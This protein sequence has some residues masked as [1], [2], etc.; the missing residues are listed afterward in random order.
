LTP[1][2]SVTGLLRAWRAG[3]GA[4]LERLT[5][6][7]YDELR[8]IARRSLRRERAGHSLQATA[9]VHE[10]YL[11]LVGAQAVEWQDRAHFFA[12]AA[13]LMRRV[14]VDHA[15]AR[16]RDKRG[17]GVTALALDE[18]HAPIDQGRG[19]LAL[20]DALHGL[21]ALDPRRGR[22][23]ELRCFGGLSVAETAAVL[24]VSADTVMRD[25]K[26]ARA[27]LRREL[28]VPAGP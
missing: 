13:R 27:W 16:A 17:G 5:P 11:R 15:R 2:G 21:T 20:D 3:D 12:M 9:L 1:S 7:V 19:L 14:L 26:L 22:V 24:G 8:R 23:V 4:A 10:A 18:A 28:R 6:L 25:W